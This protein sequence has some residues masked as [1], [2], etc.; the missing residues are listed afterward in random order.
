MNNKYA[1]V[2]GGAHFNSLGVI[3]ALGEEG[4][5]SV[6]INTD[7]WSFS[8]KSKYTLETFHI[9]KISETVPIIDRII[10]KYGRYPAIY[11]TSDDSAKELDDN[12]E[13]LK[14]KT[15]CPNCKGRL[16]YYMKK[17]VMCRIAKEAGF[18]VPETRLLSVD[19]SFKSELKKMPMPFILKPV[20]NFCGSKSDIS[21]C[22]SE[23]EIDDIVRNFRAY[24]SVLAQEYVDGGENYAVGYCG[25]KTQGHRT[26]IYGQLEKIREYPV[27]RGS[28]SYAVIKEKNDFL[29]VD[30]L[31]KFFELTE[32]SGVFDLD[33]KIVDGVPYF[34]EVN[35]RNGA[36]TYAFIK[37]G[38]NIHKIWFDQQ[39]GIDTNPSEIKETKLICEGL[40]L[41]HVFDGNIK[42]TTW[43]KDYLTADAHMIANKKDIK[44][45][46]YQYKLFKAFFDAKLSGG[47]GDR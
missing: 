6:F 27:D 23:S 45:F 20:N 47:Q 5:K 33:L 10:E 34:I 36:N 37:S 30:A 28:T 44:P 40:D 29:D 7:E 42:I 46:I 31:D 13:Y 43:L 32:F 4:I 17:D 1:V 8:E 2:I 24:K 25:C 35:F 14:E 19:E 26:E 39:S 16:G 12:Y 22:R 38:F 15:F 18:I 41:S 3:R 11:P 21:I 9:K